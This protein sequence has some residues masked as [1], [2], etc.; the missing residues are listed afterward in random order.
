VLDEIFNLKN[1]NL[2]SDED[3]NKY[4]N[5]LLD[6]TL[7]QNSKYTTYIKSIKNDVNSFKNLKDILKGKLIYLNGRL[8][9]YHTIKLDNG[10][11]ISTGMDFSAS[12]KYELIEELLKIRKNYINVE[13]DDIKSAKKII[14]NYLLE[15][16]MIKLEE[17]GIIFNKFYETSTINLHNDLTF[18]NYLESKENLIFQNKFGIFRIRFTFEGN[19]R[20]SI[21]NCD[22]LF[23]LRYYIFLHQKGLVNEYRQI[24]FL[25]D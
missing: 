21:I 18:S 5:M 9:Y 16:E 6:T 1:N 11:I 25:N 10:K 20:E 24:C 17:S 13:L 4:I 15:K 12:N 22:S 19:I 2:I 3:F 14:I 23:K 7:E 8:T